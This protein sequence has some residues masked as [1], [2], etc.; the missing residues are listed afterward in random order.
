MMLQIVFLLI[1][2]SHFPGGRLNC[3]C[4]RAQTVA[5]HGTIMV[6]VWHL[7]RSLTT[8]LNQ[9]GDALSAFMQLSR[10]E[11]SLA[12]SHHKQSTGIKDKANTAHQS[13]VLSDPRVGAVCVCVRGEG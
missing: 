1:S 8:K 2:K 6:T 13:A 5:L 11:D 12:L 3:H 10:G 4:Q 9:S 7:L